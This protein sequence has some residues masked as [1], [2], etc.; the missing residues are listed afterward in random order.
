VSS[1]WRL[2]GELAVVSVLA[3]ATT[4]GLTVTR[5]E[6]PQDAGAP[7]VAVGSAP[8]PGPPAAPPESFPLPA[9]PAA[10]PAAAAS[11]GR[12]VGRSAW[13]TALDEPAARSIKDIPAR[14]LEAYQR[15][16]IVIDLADDSCHL[17]WPLLAALA[18]VESDHGRYAGATINSDG[19]VRPF[20]LGPRLTGSDHTRRMPDTDAGRLDGDRRV[21][22]A[23]GPFQIVP[24]TWAQV[25]VDADLDGRRDPNDVDDAALAA[26][27]FLCSGPGDLATSDG[28]R[29]AVRRYNPDGGFARLVM[30]VM[31]GYEQTAGEVVVLARVTGGPVPLPSTLTPPPVPTDNDA[32]F[33]Q[34]GS[35]S[36]NESTPTSAPTA[37]SPSPSTTAPPTSTPSATETATPTASATPSD[38]P[39]DSPSDTPS[40]SP[41]A[42]GSPSDDPELTVVPTD[43]SDGTGVSL[44]TGLPLTVPGCVP[45]LWILRRR[46]HPAAEEV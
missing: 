44:S 38:T 30:D 31:T 43:G 6:A 13:R 24:A 22:R 42:P 4:V 3:A 10:R 25:Q 29:L 45:L 39:S 46:R 37:P 11:S 36:W 18:K 7:S 35:P 26:A 16:A 40:A 27:V 23:V 32:S 21:D 28:Q 34:A 14:A 15:A 9:L 8:V 41:T 2:A 33:T 12:S 19:R 20:I 17:D 1:R 5:G